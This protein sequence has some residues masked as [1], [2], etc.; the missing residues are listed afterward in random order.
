M[1]E[2]IKALDKV[3]SV[4]DH[5]NTYKVRIAKTLGEGVKILTAVQN[6]DLGETEKAFAT[7]LLQIF[8]KAE[9]LIG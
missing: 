5:G 2:L 6:A 4:L 3:I 1:D 9:A 7:R 8:T